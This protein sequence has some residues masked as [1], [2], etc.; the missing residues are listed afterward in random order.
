MYNSRISLFS[1]HINAKNKLSKGK[2]SSRRN[3]RFEC[4][5]SRYSLHWEERKWAAFFCPGPWTISLFCYLIT[6]VK[7]NVIVY[8]Y[9]YIKYK[10]RNIMFIII[11]SLLLFFVF[12]I[13]R[14]VNM[15]RPFKF[16][17]LKFSSFFQNYFEFFLLLWI[18]VFFYR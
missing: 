10:K 7:I 1:W 8:L 4:I 12:V 18:F 6:S 2:V 15:K 13:F 16:F 17:A 3:S 5:K 9:F 14:K 11:F